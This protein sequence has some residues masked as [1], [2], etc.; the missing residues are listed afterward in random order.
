MKLHLGCGKR[1]LE[2]WTNCDIF[3]AEGVHVTDIRH[4]PFD[5]NSA[6]EILAVHVCEHF[7]KHDLPKVLQEWHRVLK[8]NGTIALELPCLDRVLAHFLNGSGENMTLWALYG[9]PD[10]HKD[11][12]P[13]LHKWCWSKAAFREQLEKAGFRDIQEEVPHYHQPSR[14]MRF[15]CTK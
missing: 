6:E 15:V 1:L 14:D 4:L 3:K 8:P 11:G 2:G 10:T 5:D 13:S 7:Y 9:A 12:E